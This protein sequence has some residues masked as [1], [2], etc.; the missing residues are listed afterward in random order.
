M[1]EVIAAITTEPSP[2]LKLSPFI[3][4]RTRPSAIVLFGLPMAVAPPSLAKASAAPF[5]G[6]RLTVVAP[7]LSL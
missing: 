4:T 3:S 7:R 5:F 6:A 1:H 2:T